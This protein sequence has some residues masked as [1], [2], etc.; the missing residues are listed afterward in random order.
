LAARAAVHR[1]VCIHDAVKVGLIVED[2]PRIDSAFDDVWHEFADVAA[3]G[4]DTAAQTD[5][6]KDD[7]DRDLDIVR[8]AIAPTIEPTRAMPKAVVIDSPVPAHSG[9]ASTPRPSVIS[10]TRWIA[11]SP[12]SGRMSV[13]PNDFCDLGRR[14][15]HEGVGL[16]YR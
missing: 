13:A 5:V 16:S 1:L 15:R 2:F 8:G 11:S 9:A 14:N 3:H 4:R 6:V 12:R 7:R 10:S